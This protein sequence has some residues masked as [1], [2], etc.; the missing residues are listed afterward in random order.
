MSEKQPDIIIVGDGDRHTAV[1]STASDDSRLLW[2]IENTSQVRIRDLALELLEQRRRQPSPVTNADAFEV[3]A[4]K[5]EKADRLVEGGP[6]CD[7]YEPVGNRDYFAFLVRKFAETMTAPIQLRPTRDVIEVNLEDRLWAVHGAE[8]TKLGAMLAD[9]SNTESETNWQGGKI[10]GLVA[11]IEVVR[12]SVASHETHVRVKPLVWKDEKSFGD[13]PTYSEAVGALYTYVAEAV[14]GDTLD[15]AKVKAG[16]RYEAAILSALNPSLETNVVGDN[17]PRY[18]TKRMHDEV[19]KAKAY[20][21]CEALD[22]AATIAQSQSS[23]AAEAIRDRAKVA[24]R[25]LR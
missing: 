20:A 18:T 2:I 16:Q 17:Q 25:D 22:E 14:D 24:M 1:E 8:H 23:I 12:A 13:E 10:N 7:G 11:A 15:E 4:Q 9:K 5:I 6:W 19:A 3:L 21:R